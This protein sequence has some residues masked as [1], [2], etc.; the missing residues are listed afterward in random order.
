MDKEKI[1]LGLQLMGLVLFVVMALACASHQTVVDDNQGSV[2]HDGSSIELPN[3]SV[4]VSFD[5]ALR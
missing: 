3:D 1:G 4:A 5:Y 2:L